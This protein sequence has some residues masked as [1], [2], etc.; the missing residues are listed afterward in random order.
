MK[1]IFIL[2][3]YK[4]L[5]FVGLNQSNRISRINLEFRGAFDANFLSFDGGI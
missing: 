5:D 1:K 4:D 3:V 2:V